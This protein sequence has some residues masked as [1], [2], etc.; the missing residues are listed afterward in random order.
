MHV[1]YCVFYIAALGVVSFLLGRLFP[2]RLLR[3]DG[4]FFRCRKWERSG[5]VYDLLSVR[6]WQSKVPDMSR[7]FAKLMPPKRM[8]AMPGCEEI[9]CMI[10]ETCV[11]EA[12]HELLCIAGL[13][14]L[15]IWRGLGGTVVWLLYVLLGNLPFIVIQ[16][17]NRPRFVEMLKKRQRL[18]RR[19]FGGE[20][21]LILSCN[22]GEGHNSCSEAIRECLA[23]HNLPCEREDAL[24][25]LSP[26]MSRIVAW[27]HVHAYRHAPS[28]FKHVYR[29]AEKHP[30]MFK[31]KSPLGRLMSS[32]AEHL[33]CRMLDSG[34]GI[35]ITT[36]VI[37]A[38]M[39]TDALRRYPLSVHTG[40]VAT[41]YTCSPIVKDSALER[42]FIPDAALSA[43]FLCEHIRHGQIVSSGIP[44]RA[45]FYS[46]APIGVARV[47]FN[48]PEDSRHIVLMCGS[49]GCG[50][51][52]RI[53]EKLSKR[54]YASELLTVV[55]G[56]NERL[57]RRLARR[58]R[59]RGNIHVLGYVS[60]VSLLMDSA[61]LYM[62]KPGGLSTTEAMIKRLPMVLIDAVA[63]CEGYNARYLQKKGIAAAADGLADT[64]TLALGL[65]RDDERLAR[66]RACISEMESA[67]EIVYH[68]MI[69]A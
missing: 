43:E 16:R 7:L 36:H 65:L 40:F 46:R 60:D 61:D 34:C 53:T 4:F 67:A 42:Y 13:F 27:C 9:L 37:A 35:V 54:L 29:F 32:G 20:S 50:R 10:E 2:K 39:L 21:A 24:R 15:R 19:Y 8:D 52:G 59:H 44:V 14:L 49:M 69:S 33:Y 23:S 62:T 18:A 48:V 31:E 63:G 22:T 6:R 30:S 51:M 26:L 56:T 11:A 64:V 12:V 17:Y 55:C 45:D 68:H 28:M 1:V 66:M 3:Y 57:R 5:R 38:Y 25:F 47:A 41:D 58:Y